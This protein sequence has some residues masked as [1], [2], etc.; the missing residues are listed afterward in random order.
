MLGKKQQNN[1]DHWH[2]EAR[3][4]FFETGEPVKLQFRPCQLQVR[5]NGHIIL[6]TVFRKH[7]II[8]HKHTTDNAQ[9]DF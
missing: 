9:R 8:I 2:W 1:P 6:A 3:L 7:A 5:L 4:K